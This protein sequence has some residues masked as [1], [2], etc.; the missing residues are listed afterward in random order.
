MQRQDGERQ[1]ILVI[2]EEAAND[3]MY[4]QVLEG[5]GFSVDIITDRNKVINHVQN[6]RYDLCILDDDVLQLNRYLHENYHEFSRHII[7]TAG[8]INSHQET[9]YTEY[10]DEVYLQKPFTPGELITAVELALN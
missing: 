1:R 4:R 8:T 3:I 9:A 6:R 7:F 5:R 2:E 10:S